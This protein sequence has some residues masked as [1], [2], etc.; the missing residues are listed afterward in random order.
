M[1]TVNEMG[2]AVFGAYRLACR[3]PGGMAFFDSSREGAIKSFYA[4]AL[5]APFYVV[6]IMMR[7][8]DEMGAL[9]PAYIFTIEFLRLVIIWTAF[10]VLMIS[11]SKWIDREERY[12]AYL[13]AANWATVLTM[14]IRFPVVLTHRLELL[15]EP[16]VELLLFVVMA[17]V[18]IYVW[19][20]KKTALDITGGLAAGLTAAEFFLGALIRDVSGAII[21]GHL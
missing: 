19:Y 18:L 12:F 1:I 14:L 13:V 16:I 5:L 4:A 11:I 20:V 21:K 3:D 7:W 8:W 15:P 17:L 2:S 9:S 6:F 10:P